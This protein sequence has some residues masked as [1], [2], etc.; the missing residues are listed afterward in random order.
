MVARYTC[1]SKRELTLSQRITI[2]TEPIATDVV[3]ETTFN[4]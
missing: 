2:P 4:F 3:A 1:N